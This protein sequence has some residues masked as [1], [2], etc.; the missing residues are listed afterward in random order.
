MANI[1]YRGFS[2][3]DRSKKFRLIDFDLVKQ[4]LINHFNIK[5]GEKLMQPNFGTIIWSL[6]FEPMTDLLRNQII[7]DIK[8]VV[9]Y[10]PRIGVRNINLTEYDHGIQ[11][12]IDLVYLQTDQVSNLS[13]QFD[14]NTQTISQM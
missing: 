13:V 12:E 1:L 7:E 4:D 9:N 5:K 2:T 6:I 3:Y 10:D 8:N 14:K 11:V